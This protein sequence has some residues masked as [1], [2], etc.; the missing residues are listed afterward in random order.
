MF[1]KIFQILN[2]EGIKGFYQRLRIRFLYITKPKITKSAYGVRLHSN[3]GD[4]TF[5]L[6][7]S[8]TYGYFFSD[9]LTNISKPYN[10]IDIGSNQGIYSLVAAKNKNFKKIYAFEPVAENFK[11]LKNNI[12]LNNLNNII[13]KK[14]AISEKNAVNYISFNKAHSG[15]SSLE[16]KK[17]QSKKLIKIN[18]I[19]Y[20]KLK[21]LI[22]LKNPLIVK[23]DVEGHESVVLDQLIKSN[24]IKN[25]E[26]IY[27]E[28][29]FKINK[30]RKIKKKINKFDYVEVYRSKTIN[31]HSDFLF[32][33][34]T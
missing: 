4:A 1:L 15:S 2:E 22:D 20:T 19:N 31:N 33:K 25:V 23:I 14:F 26:F 18:T 8:G 34:V 10:F 16:I 11:L 27:V 17:I 7:L 9:F 30:I 21:K 13:S 5:N 29:D 6:C 12:K 28:I 3:W 32:K 24:L